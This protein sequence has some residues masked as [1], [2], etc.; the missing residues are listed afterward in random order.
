MTFFQTFFIDL[1]KSDINLQKY[2]YDVYISTFIFHHINH[3]L[4][5][6]KR[7]P[8]VFFFRSHMVWGEKGAVRFYAPSDPLSHLKKVL[9]RFF[10]LYIVSTQV[11]GA[12]ND[13][14]FTG[15]HPPHYSCTHRTLII[16]VH[17]KT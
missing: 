17:K 2:G 1:Q 15:S 6:K 9:Y 12:S 7:S 3:G 14:F 8:L 16:L 11:K 4:E 13:L 10:N 5:N